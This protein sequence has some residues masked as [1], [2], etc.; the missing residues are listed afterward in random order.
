MLT[1]DTLTNL[2]LLIRTENGLPRRFLVPG[3]PITLA[4]QGQP[5]V[6]LLDTGDVEFFGRNEPVDGVRPFSRRALMEPGPDPHPLEY[7]LWLMDRPQH[8]QTRDAVKGPFLAKHIAEQESL[9]YRSAFSQIEEIRRRG[10]SF[11][12]TTDFGQPFAL[13]VISS[14]LGATEEVPDFFRHLARVTELEQLNA[15]PP[16]DGLAASLDRIIDDHLARPASHGAFGELLEVFRQDKLAPTKEE[17]THIL[18]GYLASLLFAGTDTVAMALGNVFLGLRRWGM[19]DV[20]AWAAKHDDRAL[21]EALIQEAFRLDVP[22]PTNAARVVAPVRTPSGK[23][24]AEGT[25][26]V[27]WLSAA[28]R[29]SRFTNP[30][31]F[32]PGRTEPHLGYGPGGFH[33][34]LG[35]PLANLELVIATQLLLTEL[36]GLHISAK[37]TYTLGRVKRLRLMCD[38]T[39]GT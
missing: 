28:N 36:P 1:L 8:Q 10:A 4:Q 18:R 9:I 17:A 32:M 20:A 33:Y 6:H 39:R 11:S 26:V 7:A 31:T 38:F 12:L 19:W 25:I 23:L 29:G 3:T 30:N 5:S 27:S 15:Y 13:Y 24:L 16:E 34:C 22:F 35:A 21:L 37:P 2:P 14:I